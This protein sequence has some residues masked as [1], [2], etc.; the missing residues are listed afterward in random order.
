MSLYGTGRKEGIAATALIVLLVVVVHTV[1]G[2][3]T[4]AHHALP[5][6]LASL[7]P[8]IAGVTC[9]RFLRAQGRSRF[10]GF[11]AGAAYALSPWL[12]AIGQAPREQVA[13]AL[14]PLALEA[15]CRCD[16]PD[17]RPQWLPWAWICIAL[18]FLAGVTVVNV[19]G[20]ILVA[21]VLVRTAMCGDRESDA[22]APRATLLTTIGSIAGAVH[23]AWLDPF[24]AWL[25]GSVAVPLEALLTQHRGNGA[26]VDLAAFLRVPGPLLLLFAAL[27]LVRRQRHVDPATWV[28]LALAGT[29]PTLFVVWPGLAAAMPL[30]SAMPTAAPAALWLSLLATTV[31]AT[32]GLDDFLDLPQRRRTALPWLLAVTVALAPLL[33]SLLS[34]E[35]A[36]E[37]PLSL[38]LLLLA[39]LLSLWRQLGILRWKNLLAVAALLTLAIAPLQAL[40]GT[41]LALVDGPG[42]PAGETLPPLPRMLPPLQAGTFWHYTS[43]L[44]AIVIASIGSWY[45]AAQRRHSAATARIVRGAIVRPRRP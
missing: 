24:G 38:T 5:R 44:G 21:G 19:L 37:W 39:V 41:P 8:G 1:G 30:W 2:L 20:T 12:L 3:A 23:L 34:I 33:P 45:D 17:T 13:A 22:P 28:G 25:G 6:L 31:L 36:R 26:A 35:P 10:A 15:A 4:A 14:V 16:R 27:G 11:L 29:A 42:A 7:V 43:L 40:T 32:A 18:P 9:Y